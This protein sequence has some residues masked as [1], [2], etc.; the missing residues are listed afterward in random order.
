VAEM[1]TKIIILL[2]LFAFGTSSCILEEGDR[3]PKKTEAGQLIWEL[4]S[5]EIG[6]NLYAADLA[7]KL[8]LWLTSPESEKNQWEDRYFPEN[9]LRYTAGA[10]NLTGLPVYIYPDNKS[11]HTAGAKW[12]IIFTEPVFMFQTPELE[13]EIECMDN[14]KWRISNN[15]FYLIITGSKVEYPAT[16]AGY[17]YKTTGDGV[18]TP[19]YYNRFDENLIADYSIIQEMTFYPE[20]FGTVSSR[21]IFSPYSGKCSITVNDTKNSAVN[22]KILVEIL[23]GS[24]TRIVY[25]ITYNGITETWD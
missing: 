18:F 23:S 3:I 1:R 24:P 21:Y 12:R 6:K 7:L 20:K 13:L 8:D 10:W 14:L 19:G 22:D 2:M 25:K 5:E 4:T 17:I 15:E 9:K 16:A 11:I